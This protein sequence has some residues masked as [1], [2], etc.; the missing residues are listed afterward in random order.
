MRTFLGGKNESERRGNGKFA[1]AEFAESSKH[2]LR[3]RHLV[4]G[5]EKECWE[6]EQKRGRKKCDSLGPA[7]GKEE[8]E[9]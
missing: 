1:N 4:G 7:E 6:K 2:E 5:L 9:E 8:N 3:R